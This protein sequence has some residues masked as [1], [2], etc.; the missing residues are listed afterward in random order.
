LKTDKTIVQFSAGSLLLEKHFCRVS[1]TETGLVIRTVVIL[2]SQT[3]VSSRALSQTTAQLNTPVSAQT[4]ASAPVTQLPPGAKVA[5][6]DPQRIFQES[7][8]GR[9][10]MERIKTL[11]QKKQVENAA[12]QKG[13][14]DRQ[15][16]LQ[17]RASVLN[18]AA[19]IQLEKDIEKQQVEVQR[20]QQDA[21]AEINELQ[22]EVQ[23]EFGQKLSSILQQIGK[24]KELQLIFNASEPGFLWLEPALDISADV[25]KRLDLLRP[26]AAKK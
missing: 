15:Q 13:F 18:E 3:L 22:T 26:P 9:A 25:I 2:V 20:F 6:I 23:K 7:A 19:R 1:M 11:T 16:Q 4:Q 10:S 14:Q 5:F 12:K 21:Q 17:S 8:E 24:E